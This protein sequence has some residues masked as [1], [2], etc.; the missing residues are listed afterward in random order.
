MLDNL[1]GSKLIAFEAFNLLMAIPPQ[2]ACKL[3]VH[4][5]AVQDFC[6]LAQGI[7]MTNQILDDMLDTLGGEDWP[8]LYTS[9][10]M[11]PPVNGLTEIN[12][13]LKKSKSKKKQYIDASVQYY[14][15]QR[16]SLWGDR[17]I[18]KRFNF[19]RTGFKDAICFV[20]EKVQNIKRRGLCDTCLIRGGSHK[21]LCVGDTGLCGGCLLYDAAFR[22]VPDTWKTQT[23]DDIL[24]S[25]EFLPHGPKTLAV[26]TTMT[27]VVNGLTFIEA[28]LSTITEKTGRAFKKRI[29]A[30]VSYSCE[31]PPN[32]NFEKFFD[33]DRKGLEDAICFVQQTVQN[34]ERRGL[35]ETCLKR[36]RPAKRLRVGD[37]GLCTQCLLHKAVF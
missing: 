11:T 1:C 24:D 6:N 21:C 27:P 28:S 33:V 29:R 18:M 22:V 3:S 23:L 7:P 12:A 2:L 30:A 34:I 13:S 16:P 14:C 17:L 25:L 5:A 10:T 26:R 20:Q 37:T 36:Q 35:C 19:D 8:L 4:A 31:Q 15:D 32:D 9:T